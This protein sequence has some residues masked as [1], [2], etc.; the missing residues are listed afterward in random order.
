M[1]VRT[2][3]VVLTGLLL[4]GISGFI[5]LYFP[6]RTEERLLRTVA[7]EARDISRIAAFSVA[8]AL[9][10][11]DPTAGLE[12]LKGADATTDVAY[13]VIADANRRVFAALNEDRARKARYGEAFSVTGITPGASIHRTALPILYEGRQIGTLYA[14]LSLAP[15]H[16]EIAGM[17]RAIALVSAFVFLLGLLV[18]VGIGAYVTRPLSQM[19]ETTQ[20]IARGQWHRRAPLHSLDEVGELARSFNTML[21]ALDRSRSELEDLN[22]NLE[23]RVADRTIE[24]EQEILE[25]RRGEEALG[26][27]NERFVLA[28]SAVNGAIY[29]WDAATNTVVWT[30]G[31]TRVFGYPLEEV[32]PT[33]DWRLARIH[34]DDLGRIEEQLRGDIEAGRDFVGGYRFR[35]NDQAYFDVWD[36]GRVVRDGTGRVVRMVGIMENVTDFRRLEDQFR[37][38]QKMEAVGRLAGGIAHDFNNLLTTILGYSHLILGQMPPEDPQRLD[39][40]EIRKAGDRAAALTKQL[41]AFSRKQVIEP[42]VLEVN[43]IVANMEKM[44]C[45]LIGEDIQ[46]VTELDSSAGHIKADLGQLEQVIMNIVVNARDAMPQRGKLTIRTG[47]SV[48]D[49]AFVRHHVGARLGEYASIVVSDTGCGM[50]TVTKLRIFEPFFT[51]KELGKGTGLGMATVYG[52]V[53]QSEGYVLV[54]SDPGK[55]TRIRLYFPQVPEEGLALESAS[56][57]P[58]TPHGSEIILLVEDED[59]VRSLVRGILR[60]RGFT[61]LDAS[62]AAEAVRISNDFVGPIHILL[63]DVVMPEV[64]GRELADQLRQTRPEM[65]LLYMSGYTEDMIVHHG[66]LT[67][68]VGFLQKPFTPD[69]LLRKIRETLDRRQDGMVM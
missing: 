39:V 22:R 10:F 62:N 61:V 38:A 29:D 2:R 6:G 60:A 36:R 52:I 48:F 4:G 19:V 66:V 7:S 45:R 30:D 55:G 24:L 37:Q 64:S 3:L 34:P 53:K 54:D 49:E 58:P 31:I 15:V 69:K 27:A 21:D 1:T 67:S 65:R 32:E 46:C 47:S 14:G 8:P 68:D 57:D 13:V 11:G 33:L 25:R 42:K 28:A 20:E 5:Y 26:R 23:Q 41:L 9:Y 43:A 18:A 63:T 44:L 51:T 56:A 17:R 59:A 50:D 16:S 40:E 35:M 12:L